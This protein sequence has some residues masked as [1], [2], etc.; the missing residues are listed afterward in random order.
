M[1]ATERR[2]TFD[3]WLTDHRGLLFKVVRAYASSPNDQDD[4]F[5]E[6]AIRLWKSIP[7]YRGEAAETTWIYRVA[8]F[9]AI[10]WLR[11][12]KKHRNQPLDSIEHVLTAADTPKDERLDWLYEQIRKLNEVDR[13]L[14]LLLLDGFSYKEISETLGISESHVGVKIHRIKK[15][16][17]AQLATEH[18]HGI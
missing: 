7:G 18:D 16:L 10:S 17:T 4:L 15:H 13:S 9:T 14:I 3:R 2:R 8:L 11:T 5:Q 12:E 1:D 6:I